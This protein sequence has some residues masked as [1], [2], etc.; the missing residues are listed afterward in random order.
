ME[1]G[2]TYL[3]RGERPTASGRSGGSWRLERLRLGGWARA[4]GLWLFLGGG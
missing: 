4:Q 1:E 2:E 3:K